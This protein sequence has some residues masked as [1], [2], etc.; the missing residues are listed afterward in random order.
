MKQAEISRLCVGVDLHKTQFTVCALTEDGKLRPCF[1][2][3]DGL[4]ES[5]ARQI[6]EEAAK[7]RFLSKEDF[8]NRCRVGKSTCELLESFGILKGIPESNQISLFDS[9]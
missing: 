2:S 5:A 7:G 6:E 3:I 8:R 1:T 4:G 9:I